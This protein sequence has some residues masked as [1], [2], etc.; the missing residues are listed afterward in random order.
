[1]PKDKDL[2]PFLIRNTEC[3]IEEEE[4]GRER[5]RRSEKRSSCSSK[6]KEKSSLFSTYVAIVQFSQFVYDVK[7]GFAI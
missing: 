5:D 7:I 4:G 2:L 1:M 6:E 3:S